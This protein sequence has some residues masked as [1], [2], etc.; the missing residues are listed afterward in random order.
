MMLRN[1]KVILG[2]ISGVVMAAGLAVPAQAAGIAVPG[3]VNYVEGQVSLNGTS[4]NSKSV[5]STEVGANQLLETGHG[6]AEIL[7]TPGVFLRVGDNSA[8]RM[9]SPELT[10]T[11]VEI[12]KGRA[13][14]EVTQLLKNNQLVVRDDGAVTTIEKNGIYA[15][16]ADPP[17]VRVFDGKATVTVVDNDT[18]VELKKGKEVSLNGSLNAEKFDRKAAEK[19]D[20]LYQWSSVRAQY[21]EQA[22]LDASRTVVINQGWYG[23]GWYWDPYWSSY[24][25]LPGA[26]FIYS[27]FGFNYYSPFGFYGPGYYRY[28]RVYG[29]YSR[30]FRGAPGGVGHG[31]ISSGRGGSRR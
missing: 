21:L 15:F 31:S 12:A 10:N 25:F 18:S 2:I 9:V 23:A 28:P 8:I 11:Q 24:S 16:N 19:Q 4:L 30:G 6:K 5:G 1:M 22:S 17:Q 26:G 20:P 14:L 7:L 3:S 27:P 13:V 29:G